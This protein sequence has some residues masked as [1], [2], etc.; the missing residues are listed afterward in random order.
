[1][2]SYERAMKFLIIGLG[3]MGKRRIR[4]LKKLGYGDIVGCDLREDRRQEAKGKY[5]VEVIS[6]IDNAALS[7]V[8]MI[9]V[10]TPPDKHNEFIKLA[11]ENKKPVFVEASII[12]DG[13]EELN[14]LAIKQDVLI[15]PSCTMKFHPAI[16]D[17]KNIVTGGQFGKVTNF[18]YHAGQYL[19][20]WHAW[21]SVKDYYVARKETGGCRELAPFELTWIVDLLGFP[22]NTAGFYG[23]TMDVGA[24]IDD[25][26]AIALDFGGAYGNITVDVTSRYATRN[27][28]LNMERGQILWR[29]D[30]NIVKV[31]EAASQRWIHYNYPQGQTAEGYNKNIIEDMY[32]EET[33]SFIN[34]VGKKGVFPNCLD[35]DVKVLKLLYKIEGKL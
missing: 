14:N 11:I 24:D 17:I 20:D 13:L 6:H 12:L 7:K 25:T 15:A 29:W 1:M 9:V 5:E 28:I 2:K 34:A 31:Y 10:S 32:I 3:S 16:R 22:K 35:E 27:L 26:Y 33:K 30:E 21:E 4:C 8:D 18:S 23:K 19:P